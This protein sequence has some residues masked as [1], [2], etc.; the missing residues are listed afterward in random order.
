M[1]PPL[2]W[3]PNLLTGFRLI[4][5]PLFVVV[6]RDRWEAGVEGGFGSAALW[7]V[8]A[9]GTSDI[10]DGFIAR[11]WNLTTRL[12]A[13]MDAVADKSFQFTALTTITLLGRPLFSQLP[14]WLLV[15]VF[16][17]DFI[18]LT[19]WMTLKRMDR[20]IDLEHK[21]HGRVA[22]V[23]VFALIVGACLGW[24][25]AWLTPVAAVAAAA[26]VLSA[27]AYMTRAFR[28]ARAA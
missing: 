21:L 15:S 25:E 24:P 9:A 11:R 22:T 7:I 19:G 10:L 2:A 17:R 28:L 5:V 3:L 4:L 18:L 14:M 20:P 12:G 8:A 6:S 26:A 27:V 16:L 1:G 13:L 23:L